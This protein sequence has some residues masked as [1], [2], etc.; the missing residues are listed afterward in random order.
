MLENRYIRTQTAAQRKEMLRA[1]WQDSSRNRRA[2]T[3]VRGF[4][5]TLD[6]GVKIEDNTEPD[7]A[8]PN[9]APE[10]VDQ[11]LVATITREVYRLIFSVGGSKKRKK[12]KRGKE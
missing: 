3:T 2:R 5:E 8:G 12:R 7:K 11:E 9:G 1:N 4:K 10:A 6:D